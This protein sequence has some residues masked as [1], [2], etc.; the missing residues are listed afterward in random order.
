MQSFVHIFGTLHKLPISDQEF[1]SVVKRMSEVPNLGNSQYQVA[2]VQKQ[3][4]A[5]VVPAPQVV[6]AVPVA[7]PVT[8]VSI[9]TAVAPVPFSGSQLVTKYERDPMTGQVRQIQ[10]YQPAYTGYPGN[11]PPVGYQKVVYL[12]PGSGAPHQ[13]IAAGH[14]VQYASPAVGKPPSN[15]MVYQHSRSNSGSSQ[16]QAPSS[17]Q[18]PVA[19]PYAPPNPYGQHAYPPPGHQRVSSAPRSHS[20]TPVIPAPYPASSSTHPSMNAPIP[21]SQWDAPQKQYVAP[22]VLAPVEPAQPKQTQQMPVVPQ[23]NPFSF[24]HDAAAKVAP[25]SDNPFILPPVSAAS[26]TSR[27]ANP[28]SDVSID[29]KPVSSATPTDA[30]EDKN[31]CKICF[32]RD[33]DCAFLPCSHVACYHC[34]TTLKLTTCPFCRA[35]I[36]QVLKLYRA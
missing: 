15:V 17:Y 25:R 5:P 2:I 10:V 36:S 34:A 11:Y 8:K 6:Q 21:V 20:P 7:H 26:S 30:D 13:P 32:E 18:P 28:T 9:P 23:G 16:Q 29:S 12:P 19:N 33:L 35:E 14:A 22:G 27:P 3:P 1:V 31:L 24:E 4:V